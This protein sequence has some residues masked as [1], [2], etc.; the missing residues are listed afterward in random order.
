L[1]RTIALIL[2]KISTVYDD[3]AFYVHLDA[4][5]A[6]VSQHAATMPAASAAV[7]RR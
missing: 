5:E 2:R 4:L 6:F 3:S 1:C 7:L